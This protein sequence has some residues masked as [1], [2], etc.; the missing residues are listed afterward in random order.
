MSREIIAFLKLLHGG[1]N[2]GI[3]LLFVYQGILGL[4]IRR[5]DTRPF[6]VIR[7][8]RKIGPVAAVLGAS[9][10]MAGMTVLYLDAGYL[11]KYPLHF[12]TGLIIVVLIMTTWII[13]T[14]IKG[15][16]S[17]WRDRH[18]RIGISI[19]M[20]YFIQAILGLGILL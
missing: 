7:R 4:K 19:I 6:D 18:Y 1:F 3:L 9:G 2:T 15:A 20:L 17:A 12:T 10:F 5:T 13:S 16:D 8:H 14:K 11:V